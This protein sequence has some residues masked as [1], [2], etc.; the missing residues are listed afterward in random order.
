MQQV[1]GEGGKLSWDGGYDGKGD[2][3]LAFLP[4][5]HIYGEFG[6]Q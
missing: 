3:V 5:Y 4:F 6:I 1:I 2:R